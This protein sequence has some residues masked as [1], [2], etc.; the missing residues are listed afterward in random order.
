MLVQ[1][2]AIKACFDFVDDIN[3]E[4]LVDMY[5]VKWGAD[6][7]TV[8]VVTIPRDGNAKTKVYNLNRNGHYFYTRSPYLTGLLMSTGCFKF[9]PRETCLEAKI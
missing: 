3:Q 7:I 5:P 9:K 8:E 4:Y 2:L 1:D 6:Q